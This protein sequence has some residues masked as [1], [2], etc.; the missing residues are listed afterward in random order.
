M[1]HDNAQL[2]LFLVIDKQLARHIALVAEHVD[3]KAHGAKTATQFFKKPGVAFYVQFAK[4]QV[5][6]GVTHALHG[7]RRLVKA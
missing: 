4:N 5:L 6:N 3:E 1:P 7:C 2:V